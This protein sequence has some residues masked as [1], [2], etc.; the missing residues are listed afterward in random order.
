M[1]PL[2]V[3]LFVLALVTAWALVAPPPWAAAQDV[4]DIIAR[5][6]RAFYYAGS[7]MKAKVAM[8]LLTADGQER[9][10]K[11]TM[12]RR[13]VEEGG[14]QEYFL[15]FNEPADV[16]GTAFL[17]WKYPTKDDDRWLYLPALD[18]VR[19]VAAKDARSSFVGSDFTYE[20]IS[21][22]DVN[23]DTH[24]LFGVVALDGKQC[25]KTKSAPKTAAEYA[26]KISWISTQ[27]FLPL[28]EEYYT[29]AGEKYKVF[30]A[31]QVEKVGDYWTITKRTMR[32]LRTGHRTEVI[33][34][35]TAY[36]LG[37][38]D[39]VFTERSLRNPPQQ[40]IG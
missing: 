22:R 35:G 4:N 10:R 9:T 16:R 3:S 36:D 34:T 21:G 7:D 39:S 5:S 1:R 25:Y 8:R 28:R 20:D 30:T 40:W 13:D 24:T 12:L 32:N 23:Q 19:R 38:P 2:L 6:I 15:Y 33:F 11:L 29:A 18:L 31:D 14:D 37:I 26:S 17:V 27:S